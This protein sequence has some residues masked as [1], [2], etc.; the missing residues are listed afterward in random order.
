[1]KNERRGPRR[2]PKDFFRFA[3]QGE[4]EKAAT[5]IATFQTK[6]NCDLRGATQ[7]VICI[8]KTVQ[9]EVFVTKESP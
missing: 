8:D 1:M 3:A 5:A 6:S 7:A 2:R 9:N 4:E